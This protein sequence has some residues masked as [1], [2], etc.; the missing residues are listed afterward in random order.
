MLD[1]R[2]KNKLTQ[3]L[4]YGERVK[5]FSGHLAED[6]KEKLALILGAHELDDLRYPPGNRLEKLSGNRAG[7]WS[8]RI[9]K[10]WRICFQWKGGQA[11][12]IEVIDYH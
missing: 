3:K 10:Q 7:Q 6:A 8:V 12:H 1:T 4:F 5:D 11:I 9:N 2:F